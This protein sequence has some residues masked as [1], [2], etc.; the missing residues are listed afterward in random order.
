MEQEGRGRNP[1]QLCD[2]GPLT[3]NLIQPEFHIFFFFFFI[4]RMSL[5][6]LLCARHRA[7]CL[8]QR[9]SDRRPALQSSGG[10]RHVNRQLRYGVIST[11]I[12]EIRL[13]SLEN[14]LYQ[15]TQTLKLHII[16]FLPNPYAIIVPYE[17]F[18]FFLTVPLIS[19]RINNTCKAPSQCSISSGSRY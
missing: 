16:S 7:K 15:P 4:L 8:K 17:M 5:K 13:L 14:K 18:P 1:P 10:D 9:E 3:Y 12:M 11:M 19:A 6:S 2:S